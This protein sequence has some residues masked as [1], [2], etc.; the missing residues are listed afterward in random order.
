MDEWLYPISL[1]GDF[2]M[3]KSRHLEL[4]HFVINH[5]SAGK[6]SKPCHNLWA[7]YRLKSPASRLLTSPC[8]QARIKENIKAPRYWPFVRGI[9]RW[10]V[11]SPHK[12]PVTRK[13]FPFHDVI[14]VVP[15]HTKVLRHQCWIADP[16]FLFYVVW[17]SNI[18]YQPKW[19]TRLHRISILHPFTK[20]KDTDGRLRC[21]MDHQKG[22]SGSGF[23]FYNMYILVTPFWRF[24]LNVLYGGFNDVRKSN[25]CYHSQ[26]SHIQANI[27]FWI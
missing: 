24:T 12:G 16:V 14:M 22:S 13:M 25:A 19:P 15:E 5:W 9:H 17:L 10:P 21:N 27:S 26:V 23:I 11:N 7:R 1:W 18:M 2:L 6:G 20:L 3:V 4:I 8:V